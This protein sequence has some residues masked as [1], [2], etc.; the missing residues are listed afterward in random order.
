MLRIVPCVNRALESL[1]SGFFLVHSDRHRLTS[2]VLV[3]ALSSRAGVD[4]LFDD[5]YY[6][7]SLLAMWAFRE[8]ALEDQCW[9]GVSGYPYNILRYMLQEIGG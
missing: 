8:L 7:D 9:R 4:E 2:P 5:A 6:G 1:G 3:F